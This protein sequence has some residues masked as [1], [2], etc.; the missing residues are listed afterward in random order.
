VAVEGAVMAQRCSYC[1]RT[2][3]QHKGRPCIDVQGFRRVLHAR[4]CRWCAGGYFPAVNVNGV[5]VHR[6]ADIATG[7]DLPCSRHGADPG[8]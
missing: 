3:T 7:G 5:V 4:A 8:A 2:R 1:G 6:G